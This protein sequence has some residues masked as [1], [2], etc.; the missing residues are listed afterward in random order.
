MEQDQ[1]PSRHPGH[2]LRGAD[3]EWTRLRIARNLS[4]D[5]LAR[6]SGVPKSLVGLI[7]QGR[8]SPKPAEAAALLRVLVIA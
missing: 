3:T 7:C 1:T 5:A 4:L 2:R 6:E 8:I